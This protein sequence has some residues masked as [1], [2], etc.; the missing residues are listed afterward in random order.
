MYLYNILH[1]YIRKKW[2]AYILGFYILF[3]MSY[4]PIKTGIIYFIGFITCK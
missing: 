1:N 4:I 2:Y 3:S